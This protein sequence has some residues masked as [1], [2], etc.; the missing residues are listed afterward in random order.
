[1]GVDSDRSLHVIISG[2][3]RFDR[4]RIFLVPCYGRPANGGFIP[5][6]VD[7][8][9]AYTNN[10]RLPTRAHIDRTTDDDNRLKRSTRFFRIYFLFQFPSSIHSRRPWSNTYDM[11]SGSARARR[12]ALTIITPVRSHVHGT[13]TSIVVIWR[14]VVNRNMS[15]AGKSST[16]LGFQQC[17]RKTSRKS[18]A[19]CKRRPNGRPRESSFVSTAGFF[20][21][22]Y[23]QDW[24]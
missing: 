20:G 1:M 3:T 4:R 2:D 16:K 18:L 22:R 15:V 10:A 12:S 19:F 24:C 11:C 9:T 21:A 8:P 17:T 5:K 7:L 14:G 13:R 6:T 23:R